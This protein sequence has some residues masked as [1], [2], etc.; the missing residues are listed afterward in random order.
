MG[1][2]NWPLALAMAALLPCVSPVAAAAQ[3]KPAH[4][5]E[6]ASLKAMVEADWTAQEQRRGRTPD[7]A[8]A[9]RDAL[10]RAKRLLAELRRM[11]G[12]SDLQREL[13]AL[14]E[15]QAEAEKLESLDETARR[16]L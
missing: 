8:E 16:S 2:C 4:A 3:A 10:K 11:R 12:D 15:L 9:I 13:A 5:T 6:T 1:R 7:A 14:K